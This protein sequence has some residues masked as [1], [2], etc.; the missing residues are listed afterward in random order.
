MK[1]IP[2]YN[3]ECGGKQVGC[4]WTDY[5]VTAENKCTAIGGIGPKIASVEYTSAVLLLSV[6]ALLS[7]NWLSLGLF[8][9]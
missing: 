1:T 7:S 6:I 4:K 8:S 2:N 3:E 9:W 5:T